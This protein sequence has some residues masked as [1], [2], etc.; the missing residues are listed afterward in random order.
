[1]VCY[2]VH[3]AY[4]DRALWQDSGDVPVP[5][6]S[7]WERCVA[8]QHD[9]GSRCDGNMRRGYRIAE[10]EDSSPVGLLTR[11]RRLAAD[12]ARRERC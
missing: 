6:H 4:C 1:M 3:C 2:L 7:R 5:E 12:A 9:M 11:A 8:V 10:G